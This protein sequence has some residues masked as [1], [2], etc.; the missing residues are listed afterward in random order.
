VIN[1]DGADKNSGSENDDV[2]VRKSSRTTQVPSHLR[3][4]DLSY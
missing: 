4:Y 1:E 2:N 3:D